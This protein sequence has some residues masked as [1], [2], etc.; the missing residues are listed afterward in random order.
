[1]RTVTANVL[2]AVL[3]ALLAIGPAS[4]APKKN[5][6]TVP[7][8]PEGEKLHLAYSEL[9]NTLRAE[10]RK[11]VPNVD[12]N[13]QAAFLAAHLDEGP[14]FQK[15]PEGSK[16]KPEQKRDTG[17][18]KDFKRQLTTLGKARPIL[19]SMNGFLGSNAS[20]QLLVKAAVLAN[21]TPRGLA[22]Y[23]Q[24]GPA[25]KSRIDALLADHSLAIVVLHSS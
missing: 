10:I 1:M 22:E 6:E 7:L 9:L 11:A 8:T 25:A 20:D 21:A 15:V 19:S 17:I 4:A 18:Y 5:V 14:K 24:Q 2:L 3:F 16:K 12:E 23:A 13:Q